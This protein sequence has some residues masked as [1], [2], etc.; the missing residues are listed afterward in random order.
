MSTSQEERVA[1][2]VANEL[3]EQEAQKNKDSQK[4]EEQEIDENQI[5]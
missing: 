1:K 4:K 3:K 2:D 5:Q